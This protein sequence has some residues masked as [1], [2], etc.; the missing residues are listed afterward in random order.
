[1]SRLHAST[2]L[3]ILQPSRSESRVQHGVVVSPSA[4]SLTSPPDL[5]TTLLALPSAMARFDMAIHNHPNREAWPTWDL[6]KLW[7]QIWEGLTFTACPGLQ[8]RGYQYAQ[9]GHVFSA[10][11]TVCYSYLIYEKVT[12]SY[13]PTRNIHIA[14][15]AEIW[16]TNKRLYQRT[17]LCGKAFSNDIRRGPSTPSRLGE[18]SA[19]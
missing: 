10:Y 16:L 15:H 8:D 7:A 5:F 13:S 11:D 17:S 3:P 4:V 2:G 9:F 6:T 12:Y 19:R 18:V 1:M 14:V